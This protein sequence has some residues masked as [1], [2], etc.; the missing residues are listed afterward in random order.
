MINLHGT[1]VA[2]V[3]PFLTDGTVDTSGLANVTKHVMQG[4][5]YI[6]ALGTTGE[7]ATLTTKEKDLVLDTVR[8]E[9]AGKKPL[10]LGHG[11]NDTAK[12]ISQMKDID[13]SGIDAVLSVSP[14]YNKPSQAGILAHY[15]AFADACPVPVILYNVPGRTGSNISAATTVELAG[16]PNIIGIKEASG[17]VEQS[18]AI[19]KGKSEEFVLISGDDLLTPSLIAIGAEGVISVLANA[20]PVEFNLMVKW[21]VENKYAEASAIWKKWL[22]LNPLLYEEGNPVGIKAVMK[23]LGL[24]GDTVRLPLLS[25]SE[26]LAE[27]IRKTI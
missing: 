23:E 1:G 16:H 22:D 26:G 14:F 19:A 25:A 27:R 4:V 7:S 8:K 20:W 9:I 10:V 17:N 21:S 6:V 2:L 18:M 24:C 3:T 15:R 11:G 13:F 5:D 12:L